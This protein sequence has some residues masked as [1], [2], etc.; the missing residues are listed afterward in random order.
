[1]TSLGYTCGEE[2]CHEVMYK[3]EDIAGHYR[4][5]HPGVTNID[6]IHLQHNETGAKLCIKNVYKFIRSC[7][8]H[9]QCS[10]FFVS[11]V[12]KAA[13]DSLV[14]Q[15]VSTCHSHVSSPAVTSGAQYQCMAG[16]E[17][18]GN[19]TCPTLIQDTN[20]IYA[21]VK[22]WREQH[23][24]KQLRDFVFY[25]RN[26][27][28]FIQISDVFSHVIKCGE[29]ACGLV[30]YTNSLERAR[31]LLRHHCDSVHRSLANGLEMTTLDFLQNNSSISQEVVDEAPVIVTGGQEP[32]L[33]QDILGYV[34]GVSTCRK[35]FNVSKTLSSSA[36]LNKLKSHFSKVHSS[37]GSDSFS[38]ETKFRPAEDS[39]NVSV[40]METPGPEDAVSEVTIYQCPA[41]VKNGKQCPE[42]AMDRDS[43]L[44]HWGSQHNVDGAQFCP[45]ELSI[46]T[47]SHYQCGV[48]RCQFK[49]LSRGPV[50]THWE[51]SHQDCTDKFFVLHNKIKKL[52]TTSS[53][54]SSSSPAPS[55]K[56]F[57]L[58]ST[59]SD[60]NAAKKAKV[61]CDVSANF[62]ISSYNLDNGSS[63]NTGDSDS[64]DFELD[65]TVIP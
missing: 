9:G 15:H 23:P 24:D 60:S 26:S 16:A 51:Q 56:R 18:D 21:S 33:S 32:A 61:E 2:T 20:Y 52:P 64:D 65:Y 1:M 40:D 47:V 11:N 37:L 19:V 34:C 5:K 63:T 46:D 7:S 58:S 49:H 29:G 17:D 10:A 53:T 50:K 25:E 54:P 62:D 59:S 41:L 45:A 30:V 35:Q 43:L 13:V 39:V 36:A 44:I 22:H 57:R 55:K 6:T 38:Y 12:S 8:G 14:S 27:G 42:L 31:S 28:T 48:S 3:T 4:D